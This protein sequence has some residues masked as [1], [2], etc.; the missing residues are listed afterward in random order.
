M[1]SYI[2]KDKVVEL[3]ADNVEYLYHSYLPDNCLLISDHVSDLD[4][5]KSI[6]GQ[7]SCLIFDH[8]TNPLD[9]TTKLAALKDFNLPFYILSGTYDYFKTSTPDPRIK[10]FPFWAIWASYQQYKFSLT[11]KR[12]NFSCLN[13]T[14]WEHRKL[15]YLH[16]STKD[17]FP[18]I[19][20][21][22]GN[23]P[24]YVKINNHSILTYKQQQRFDQLPQT[25]SFLPSDVTCGIDLSI[26]HPAYQETYVNLVTETTV[27][28]LKPMVSEKTFKPIAAGQLFILIASPNAVEFLRQSGIDC[29]DD[30]INHGYNTVID[31]SARI[32]QALDQLDLLN[33][34]DLD[35]LYHEIKPRLLKNSRY[36]NSQKFRDQFTLNFG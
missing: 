1:I 32:E 34:R 5:I 25:V 27:D 15:T 21:T 31:P 23:R 22:F 33:Q 17:Y 26:D 29:F 16:L 30:I 20:F 8:S 9:A 2:Q 7:F 18:D 10:F 13:G 3:T 12:Y 11:E 14:P 19:V 36:F 35:A 24:D 6:A 4:Y 28:R